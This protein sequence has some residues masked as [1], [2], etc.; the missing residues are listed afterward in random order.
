MERKIKILRLPKPTNPVDLQRAEVFFGAYDCQMMVGPWEELFYLGEE[1]PRVCRFCKQTV[2]QVEFT[3]LAH[4]MPDF[5]GNRNI[6]SYFECDSCN[7]HFGKYEASFANYLGLDRTF[8]QIKG[9]GGK[10]PTFMD[11]A[12]GLTVSV[13]DTG[14]HIESVSGKTDLVFN[15]ELKSAE[16][17]VN[18][19]GY[20]PIHVL[21]LL[22]KIGFCLLP[23]EELIHYEKLRRLLITSQKDEIIRDYALLD[24]V[25][26][27]VPGPPFF[28]E[29]FAQLYMR[30]PEA[31]ES[32]VDKVFLLYYANYYMQV[33]M[34]FSTAEHERLVACHPPVTKLDVPV[35][36][37][38]A[39]AEHL[40]EYGPATFKRKRFT[41]T[42][43]VKGEKQAYT[44]QFEYRQPLPLDD[45]NSLRDDSTLPD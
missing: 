29:P 44:L 41:S 33:V 42:K 17:V 1:S 31:R 10:I 45:D 21:K 30:K 16:L 6:V 43:K 13:D 35:F 8:S 12:G 36:P 40:A 28:S 2:P 20:V 39:S 18:K 34:P 4:V 15:E 19:S 24:V 38:L 9:K 26:H 32:L 7:Q 11:K 3:R 22:L 25:I 23:E 5:M 27:Y 14:L 37:V